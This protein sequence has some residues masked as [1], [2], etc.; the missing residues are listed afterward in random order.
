MIDANVIQPEVPTF[1]LRGLE[2][3]RNKFPDDIFNETVDNEGLAYVRCGDCPERLFKVH[4]TNQDVSTFEFHLLGA[5]HIEKVHDRMLERCAPLTITPA[6]K[7]RV[8]K[9]KTKMSALTIYKKLSTFSMYETGT[10][11]DSPLPTSMLISGASSH[12]A[13]SP[14]D[15]EETETASFTD[16]PS[17]PKSARLET[18]PQEVAKSLLIARAASSGPTATSGIEAVP[19]A[20]VPDRKVSSGTTAHLP[21]ADFKIL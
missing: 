12:S 21:L 2:D 1:V 11:S 3:L 19:A 20:P 8:A 9:L 18:T 7:A 17:I 15:L 6:V 5:R 10:T 13:S 4:Y 16:T 14:S